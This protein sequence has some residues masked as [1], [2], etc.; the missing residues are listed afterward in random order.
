MINDNNLNILNILNKLNMKYFNLI[1]FNFIITLFVVKIKSSAD[2]YF[3]LQLAIL[4]LSAGNANGEL[5]ITGKDNNNDEIPLK[6]DISA[7]NTNSN[8]VSIIDIIP[9]LKEVYDKEND[10]Q[11]G[12]EAVKKL[13]KDLYKK[14]EKVILSYTKIDSTTTSFDY[15]LNKPA[16]QNIDTEKINEQ[17]INVLGNKIYIKNV[18][19]DVDLN[20]N[21]KSN[22]LFLKENDRQLFVDIMNDVKKVNSNTF[23]KNDNLYKEIIRLCKKSD[24]YINNMAKINNI[25]FNI[26]ETKIDN[27]YYYSLIINQKNDDNN[28]NDAG[29]AKFIICHGITITKN[30]NNQYFDIIK[31][32]QLRYQIYI[33]K[34]VLIINEIHMLN[35]N[36]QCSS[37]FSE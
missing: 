2:S 37:R 12:N 17:I 1:L 10:N 15:D 19:P 20:D 13:Y 23:E 4:I 31:P 30:D 34:V 22:M 29:N 3:D 28:N 33:Y 11:K 27:E 5:L 8:F 21:E 6:I 24:N 32:F 14:A 16:H 18:L 7:S 9:A 25:S 36:I 26:I 35:L